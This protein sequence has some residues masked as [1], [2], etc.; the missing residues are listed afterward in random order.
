MSQNMFARHRAVR[1]NGR[2]RVCSFASGSYKFSTICCACLAQT[3][4]YLRSTCKTNRISSKEKHKINMRVLRFVAKTRFFFCFLRLL[5]HRWPNC[6]RFWRRQFR[7][8]E[9]EMVRIAGTD[10]WKCQSMNTDIFD[11]GIGLMPPSGAKYVLS[12]TNALRKTDWISK[13]RRRRRRGRK[14]RKPW[15]WAKNSR[16]PNHS[17]LTKLERNILTLMHEAHSHRAIFRWLVIVS[18]TYVCTDWDSWVNHKILINYLSM[19]YLG[20]LNGA[21]L[22]QVRQHNNFYDA[23]RMVD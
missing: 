21:L 19:L 22:S 11:G 18:Y 4:R 20:N 14:N 1:N 23:I 8:K 3:W 7:T 6:L 16:F 12:H 9:N 5:L 2:S 13:Q 10:E 15:G 17:T